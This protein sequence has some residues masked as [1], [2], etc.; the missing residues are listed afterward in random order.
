MRS[1]DVLDP[2]VLEPS[3][4]ISTA[5]IK[6]GLVDYRAAARFI[7]RLPYGRNTI[8]DEPLVV[9]RERRGTCSTKHALLRRLAAE[10]TIDVA[11]VVGI[12]EMHQRNTPG[13]GPIL[14]KYGLAALP[15][16]HC[17][18]RFR[19]HRVDVTRQINAHSAQDIAHFLHEED[20]T[21]EQIRAYKTT[22]HRN[23]LQRWLAETGTAAG[24]GIEEIWRIREECIAALSQ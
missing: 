12:Y 1:W 20:I 17:Y 5:F 13:V 22:L 9:M 11:L 7:S 3:G 23:F 19:Q 6:V 14:K 10:Q 4:D 16:A 8:V 24:R 18:L 21:P 2:V 15:E